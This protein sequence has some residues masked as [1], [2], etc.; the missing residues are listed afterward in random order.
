MI[1]CLHTQICIYS[2]TSSVFCMP[3]NI[4]SEI[5]NVEIV[6]VKFRALL[7][8]VKKKKKMKEKEGMRLSSDNYVSYYASRSFAL[9]LA[10]LFLK[11]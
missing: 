6:V 10:V 2:L 3:L 8:S 1:K 4:P 11:Y 9:S 5:L 7:F